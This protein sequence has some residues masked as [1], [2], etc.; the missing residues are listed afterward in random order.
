[1][2]DSARTLHTIQL[3]MQV[4]DAAPAQA[5]AGQQREPG[6]D[7]G[8]GGFNDWANEACLQVF[9]SA[10]AVN[11]NAMRQSV[12]GRFCLLLVGLVPGFS[13]TCS[14]NLRLG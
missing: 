7:K 8:G 6:E 1:M 11:Q 13:M 9:F 12:P 5:R 3:R 4:L 2:P 10:N 14:M